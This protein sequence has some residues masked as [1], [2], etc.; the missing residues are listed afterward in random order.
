MSRAS[1]AVTGILAI[2]PGRTDS[3]REVLTGPVLEVASLLLG[4]R[5]RH[6]GVTIRITEVEAYDGANDPGSHAHNGRTERNAVMFGPPGHLYVY[7]VYGMHH[8]AN[9][10]TGPTGESGAVL[11]RAGEVVGGID[12]VRERRPGVRDRDLARGPAR[13]CR[14]L[15]IDLG[16]NGARVDLVAGEPPSGISTGPRVGLRHAA[17]RPWRFWVSDDPTVSTYRPAARRRTTGR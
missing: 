11:L 15:G 3:L 1:S 10:V 7:F 9:L 16:D 5:L 13:L 14:A 4:A 6:D 17:D 12:V 8:C 2:M